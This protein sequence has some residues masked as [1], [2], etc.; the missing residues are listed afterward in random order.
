VVYDAESLSSAEVNCPSKAAQYINKDPS[1]LAADLKVSLV[2]VNGMPECQV[3]AL[4][5][6]VLTSS[7]RDLGTQALPI[8]AIL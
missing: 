6:N 2:E 7:I 1:S 4:G 5:H 8:L 3:T